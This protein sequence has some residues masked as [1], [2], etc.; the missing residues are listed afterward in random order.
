MKRQSVQKIQIQFYLMPKIPIIKAKDFFKYITKFNCTEISIRGSH[1]KIKNNKNG[2]VSII[3]IHS[4]E[5]LYPAMFQAIL[6]QLG[7][8]IND[9][10]EFIN[11]K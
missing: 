11:K 2:K 1:H 7:I 10:I 6:K 9:F 8:N 4:N 3:A 5:D